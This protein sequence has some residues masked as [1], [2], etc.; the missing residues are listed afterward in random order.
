MM[1]LLLPNTRLHMWV[2]QS[3]AFPMQALHLSSNVVW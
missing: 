2:W 3:L 1:L